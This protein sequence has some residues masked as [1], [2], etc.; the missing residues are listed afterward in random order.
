MGVTNHF[1]IEE[2]LQSAIISI[3][4]TAQ[5]NQQYV[6]KISEELD[7]LEPT[8]KINSKSV[9]N[10]KYNVESNLGMINKNYKGSKDTFATIIE[11]YK[12]SVQNANSYIESQKSNLGGM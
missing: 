9:S 2:E 3:I 10:K 6:T 11:K 5:E 8:I 4:S 7:A 1:I 12:T